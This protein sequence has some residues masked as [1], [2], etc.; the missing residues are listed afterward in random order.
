MSTNSPDQL[1][2]GE[3]PPEP[4]VNDQLPAENGSPAAPYEATNLQPSTIR[5]DND[6]REWDRRSVNYPMTGGQIRQDIGGTLLTGEDVEQ[7]EVA[8]VRRVL[9]SQPKKER[10]KLPT[11]GDGVQSSHTA[12]D[13]R[14]VHNEPLSDEAKAANREARQKALDDARSPETP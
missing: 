13:I 8:A 5:E 2:L 7:E 11:I 14:I 10:R 12:A 6:R 1:K 3:E 4:V 9:A